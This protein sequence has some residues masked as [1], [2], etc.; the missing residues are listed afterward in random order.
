[1]NQAILLSLYFTAPIAALLLAVRVVCG[2]F[3]ARVRQE[4]RRYPIVH[5]IWAFYAV[6]G[7]SVL[8]YFSQ[9]GAR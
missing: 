3:S 9:L 7:M 1:M 5:L 2:A 4:I 6:V 8:L